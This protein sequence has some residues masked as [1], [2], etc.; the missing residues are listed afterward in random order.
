MRD[1]VSGM[2]RFPSLAL[3]I[4]L[5]WACGEAESEPSALD[6]SPTSDAGSSIPSVPPRSAVEAGAADSASG[7]PATLVITSAPSAQQDDSTDA[8]FAFASAGLPNVECRL[9]AGA[10]TPCS[11]PVTYASLG[12]GVHTFEVRAAN[13]A[14]SPSAA[15]RWIVFAPT[16][17]KWFAPMP[18]VTGR[19]VRADFAALPTTPGAWAGVRAA[20][21]V[22]K[23]YLMILPSDSGVDLDAL[24]KTV[25]EAGLRTAFE[26]GGLRLYT[27]GSCGVGVLGSKT[28]DAEIAFLNRWTAANGGTGR[29][30]F[31]SAD[32]AIA[33]V[34]EQTLLGNCSLTL[35]EAAAELAVYFERIRLAFPKAKVGLIESLGYWDIAGAN[36]THYTKTRGDLPTITLDAALTA[37]IAS[38]AARGVTVEHFDI[39]FGA[40]GIRIDYARLLQQGGTGVVVNAHDHG[41]IRAA[42]QLAMQKG[43][44]SGVIYNSFH[45]DG[46]GGVYPTITTYAT[47]PERVAASQSARARTLEFFDE[48]KTVSGAQGKYVFQFWQPFPHL[49]S[50]ESTPT[51]GMG[52]IED[53]LAR[54]P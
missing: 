47:E 52:I 50:P 41:R 5:A 7:P 34:I 33:G 28:A 42:Q 17:K 14:M 32:H 18:F 22:F 2:R 39:D 12:K 10:F 46:T 4:A 37:V 26:V 8:T 54:V 27:P 49:T 3:V 15:H 44:A 24:V 9:D 29:I 30:D 1:K 19:T 20:A 31:I 51:T 35:A 21:D 13:G 25:N 38:A 43:L 6:G 53:L 40:E 48:Y 16:A 36:G 11:S 23:S 45:D